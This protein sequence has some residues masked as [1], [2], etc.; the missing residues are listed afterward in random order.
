MSAVD[1]VK[2]PNARPVWPGHRSAT[3]NA[4]G[5]IEPGSVVRVVSRYGN[6]FYVDR[7]ALAGSAPLLRIYTKGGKLKG[8][9]NARGRTFTQAEPLHRE[10]IAFIEGCG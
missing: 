9:F 5:D 8:R 1:Q 3:V 10:N 4:H 6:S 7:E 2:D